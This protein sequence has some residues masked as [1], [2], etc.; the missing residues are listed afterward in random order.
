[1]WIELLIKSAIMSTEI[2]TNQ[3]FTT[4]QSLI[5]YAFFIHSVTTPFIEYLFFSD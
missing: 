2:P 5:G 1:M 3:R 4:Y